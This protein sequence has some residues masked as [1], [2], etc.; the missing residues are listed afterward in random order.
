M[1]TP[2][3]GVA[4]GHLDIG[5]TKKLRELVKIPPVHHVP[6]RKG[7]TQIVEPEVLNLRSF[8]QVLKTSLQSLASARCAPFGGK[9][10]PDRSPLGTAEFP[11]PAPT[12]W[13]HNAPPIL[14]PCPNCQ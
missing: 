13:G 8:E 14:Q 1:R 10:D 2:Q 11:R 7:V 4:F 5:V 3:I 12:T 9:S 6:G